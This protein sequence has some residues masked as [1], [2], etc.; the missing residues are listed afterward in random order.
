[1]SMIFA[2]YTGMYEEAQLD[3]CWTSES[4]ANRRARLLYLRGKKGMAGLLPVRIEEV[5][6]DQSPDSTR[7]DGRPKQ[8]TQIVMRKDG[9]ITRIR[10]VLDDWAKHD[11]GYR[12]HHAFWEGRDLPT[13][14]IVLDVKGNKTIAKRKA[15]SMRQ[16]IIENG[17]WPERSE[18]LPAPGEW[19]DREEHQSL[20]GRDI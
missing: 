10:T 19:S 6:L 12:V 16:R 5:I 20:N 7:E 18:H 17:A 9:K 11:G 2:V 3:S 1:M 14:K 8:W 15:E 4:K 13:G